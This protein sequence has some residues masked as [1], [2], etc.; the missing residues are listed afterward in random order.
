MSVIKSGKET[1]YHS[2]FQ[3]IDEINKLEIH[4]YLTIDQA[5]KF[6]LNIC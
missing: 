5:K 4:C 1:F 3:K 6:P 2:S